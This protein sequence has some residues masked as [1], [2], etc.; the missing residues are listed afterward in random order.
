S[1]LDPP[2]HRTHGFGDLFA[3]PAVRNQDGGRIRSVG[4][5]QEPRAQPRRHLIHRTVHLVRPVGRDQHRGR[6]KRPRSFLVDIAAMRT[7]RLEFFDLLA[8]AAARHQATSRGALGFSFAVPDSSP[9]LSSTIWINPKA[10][11]DNPLSLRYISPK[12]RTIAS[13]AS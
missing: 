9:T 13:G 11:L 3:S 7:S 10:A 5:F 8:A 4:R 12:R 1:P 6:L 2:L